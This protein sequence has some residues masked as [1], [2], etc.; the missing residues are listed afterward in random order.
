M[1]ELQAQI[2]S[3]NWD[4]I[5]DKLLDFMVSVGGRLIIAVLIYLI[6]RLLIRW[7]LR[8]YDKTESVSR[9]D[10]TARRYIRNC[11]CVVLY[12][13]LIVS[14]VAE[15]G[16]PMSSV[17]TVIASCGV[18]VGLGLQGAFTNFAGGLMLLIFRPF[19][20]ND[21]IVAGGYEGYVRSISL[22]YTVIRTWDNRIISIPN[23]SLMNSPV[24]NS[25]SEKLRRVDISFNISGDEP[26]KKVKAEIMKVIINT[27]LALAKPSP[28]VQPAEAVPGGLRYAVRV[29]A[30]TDHY[31]EVFNELMDEI[32]MA[33]NAAG[34]RM[35]A[36]PVS[37]SY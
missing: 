23:G 26:V 30:E 18:T 9:L 6:G 2:Q 5:A 16:V 27:D 12:T 11:L 34:I 15:I 37:V 3:T 33:L 17:I 1:D 10:E 24:V 7:T 20:V 32:P 4:K 21:Y 19:A 25:T 13:T 29:W 14:I 28:E 36:A 22:L 35:A 8:L 31:W